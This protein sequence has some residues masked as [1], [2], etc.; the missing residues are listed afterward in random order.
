MVTHPFWITP[1]LAIVPRPRGG[2]W[3]D[4]EMAAMRE[5]GIGVVVSMLEEPEAAELGLRGEGFAAQGAG[6]V[7]LN[8][9]IQDRSI[10]THTEN[11]VAFLDS[12][13]QLIS[14]GKAV[15]V[16]CRACIGRAS[17]VAAGL[18]VRQGSPHEE[19]WQKVAVARG[20]LVPDTPEQRRWI[21]ENVM[22][23]KS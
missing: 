8:H 15:G 14:D 5:A 12:L 11:F 7:F 1:K 23:R 9:S 20:T 17:L 16:H 22:P 19:A 10:P 13:D 2:D 3:L 18:L 6:L 21:E 4:D